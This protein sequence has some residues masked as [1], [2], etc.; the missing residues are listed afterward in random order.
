MDEH[1]WNYT[2]I[3]PLL[4]KLKNNNYSIV[5]IHAVITQFRLAQ[6]LINN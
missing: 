3:I 5:H 1:I 6:T 2:K 4:N